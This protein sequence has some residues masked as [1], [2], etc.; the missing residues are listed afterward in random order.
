MGA[1]D[2]VGVGDGDG[3]VQVLEYSPRMLCTAMLLVMLS[4][5]LS[6]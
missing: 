3:L 6:R 4:R 2:P 5:S 1:K